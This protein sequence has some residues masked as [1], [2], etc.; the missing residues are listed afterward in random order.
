MEPLPGSPQPQGAHWDGRG[1]NFALYSQHA[2]G[3]DVCLLGADGETR[4]PLEE[5]TAFVWHGYLP[6]VAPGQAYA[7]RVDGPRDPEHGHLFDPSVLLLDP[8]ARQFDRDLRPLVV[9]P[10]VEAHDV[11]KPRTPWA[12]TVIYEAHVKGLTMRHPDVDAELRGTYGGVAHP[13]VVE[14]LTA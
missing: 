3:V 4:V 6:G 5:R 12:E 14:H 9:D 7:Y 1:T 8:Y 11:P 2:T 10:A 13:A